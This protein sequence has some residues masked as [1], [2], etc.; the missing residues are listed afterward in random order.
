[1]GGIVSTSTKGENA[2]KP[3][4]KAE[5]R[6]QRREAKELTKKERTAAKSGSFRVPDSTSEQTIGDTTSREKLSRVRR[7]LEDT[8]MN[9]DKRLESDSMKNLLREA[10]ESSA[11]FG[12]RNHIQEC[13]GRLEDASDVE[14]STENGN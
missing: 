5:E 14:D 7:Y 1:M 8:D 3:V 10:A 12:F 13:L 6:R 9:S 2:S 4:S 11:R